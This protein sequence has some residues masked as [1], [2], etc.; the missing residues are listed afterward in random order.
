MLLGWSTCGWFKV[1]EPGLELGFEAGPLVEELGACKTPELSAG[2]WTE[3][4]LE[5]DAEGPVLSLKVRGVPYALSVCGGASVGP[6][7]TVLPGAGTH[8]GGQVVLGA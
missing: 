3:Y 2:R 7:V 6:G 1:G 4:G 8:P 5:L